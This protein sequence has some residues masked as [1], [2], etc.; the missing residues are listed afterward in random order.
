M[1]LV[2][3]RLNDYFDL[4]FTQEQADFAIPFLHEDIPLYVDPFLL[5]KSPSQ[6][7]QA[8]HG[9]IVNSFNRL[10]WLVRRGRAEEAASALITLSEC[11]EVGMGTAATRRGLRIGTGTANEILQLFQDLPQ[12]A[13]FGFTHFE[14]IQF[15]VE[16]ISKDRISDFACC[17]LKSFLIDYTTDACRRFGVPVERVVVPNVYNHTTHRFVDEVVD[18]PVNPETQAPLLLVPK[19]WLRFLPWLNFDDF[20]TSS[21]VEGVPPGPDGKRDRVAVLNYN[22]HN[23]GVVQEYVR[24]RELRQEDC[25]NDP[26]FKPIP[27]TFAKRKLATIKALPSGKSDNADRKYEQA[28]SELLASLLYPDLDYADLQS[29]TESGVLIRDLI[30]YNNRSTDFLKDIHETYSSRQIVFELKN[31]QTIEREHVNQLN[32]YLADHFGRF[33][34]FVTRHPLPKAMLQSTIDLWSG[35]RKCIVT[36]TDH[37]LETMVALFEG[38]QRPPLDVLKK[39]YV[40]FMRKVPS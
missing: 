5:F 6:Q 19:R 9:L 27:V 39:C 21:F 25:K 16:H 33:G 24:A 4:P 3:P 10:G 34:V 12:I 8:L 35:P 13:E 22:R 17:L 30:F 7:D 28:V 32:R 36:M 37:D 18:V 38:K 2:K 23:Y 11:Q 40:E 20:F 15:F 1:A 14:E 29:R 31:V 26:L